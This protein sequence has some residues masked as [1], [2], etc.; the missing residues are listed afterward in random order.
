MN[1]LEQALQVIK[2]EADAI[3]FLYQNPPERLN[4]VIQLLSACKGR[5]IVSGVGK[6]A[7]IGQKITATFNST[8]TP[9]IFLHAAD[10]LHGDI[11]MVQEEDCVL[12]LSK[13]GDTDELKAM[14][15]VLKNMGNTVIALTCNEAS[16]LSSQCHI[17][18]YLPLTTEA[19]PNNL[20]PTTSTTL[21]LV[22]GDALAIALLHK[23][24]FSRDQFAN[25]HPGGNLGKQLYTRVADIC[26]HNVLPTVT[27]SSTLQQVILS[28]TSGRMGATVVVAPEGHIEGLI[29]D[30]DLR[31]L[32][33]RSNIDLQSLPASA[34][35]T[36]NPK[37]IK[38]HEMAI[39]AFTM[40]RQFSIT[41]LPVV[42]ESETLVG[43]IHLHDLIKEGFC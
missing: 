5:I 26:H 2:Q 41:Q 8:G 9:S 15:P 11:G 19:D 7:I 36:P 43:I 42:N 1:V 40:M 31:R 20:A 22:M 30:G 27:A 28:I 14:V 13:S 10:A 21:Q 12:L 32:L 4:E 16:Y 35:M 23:K 17:H 37:K 25:F 6:S 38:N 18:L 24:G 34:F 33:M 39:E 3:N 29:T